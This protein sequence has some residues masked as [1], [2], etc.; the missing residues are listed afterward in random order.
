MTIY[1]HLFALVLLNINRISFDVMSIIIN[2]N[3]NNNGFV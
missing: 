2:N 1:L 3:N